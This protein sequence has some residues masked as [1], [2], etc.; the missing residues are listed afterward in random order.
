MGVF[1][2]WAGKYNDLGIN[3]IPIVENKKPP[4]DG[5]V[6]KKWLT[7]KQTEEDIENLIMA[8]GHCP[9][10]AVICG[11]VSGV[12]GFDFD[13]KYDASRMP[14]EITEKKYNMEFSKIDT[15][16]KKH[17]PDW[18][19]AKKAKHGWTV[20]YKWSP[21]H[22]TIPVDRHKVRLFDFKATGYIVIPPSFHSFPDGK[23]L[24]YSWICGDPMD[25]FNSLPE[26]DISIVEDFKEAFGTRSKSLGGRHG[27][28]FKYAADLVRI[29]VDDKIIA[30]KIMSYDISINASDKK[31]PYFKDKDHVGGD[32]KAFALK[33]VSRIRSFV[34]AKPTG[35]KTRSFGVGAWDHF[36][37]STIGEI[38][39]DI[40]SKKLFFR[41][42]Q[43]ADWDLVEGIEKVFKS[44]A[45]T[46]GFSKGDVPDELARYCF[47]KAEETFLCEIEAWEGVDWIQEI[48]KSI[49]SPAFNTREIRDIL[50]HW[51]TG[52][53][54]RINSGGESQNRCLIL[55]GQQGIGKDYLV[56]ELLKSF[57]PYYEV[58]SPPDQKKDWFEVVS[59]IY[60]AHIEEFDQ[61][62][63]TSVALLKSLITQESVFFRESYGKA[64]VNGRTAISFISTVNPDNFFR[65]STGNRR[66]VVLPVDEINHGYPKGKS[67]QILAQ[68]K[69][70][71]DK[72]GHFQLPAETEEKIKYIVEAL[73]PD[74]TDQEI[75]QI[76]AQRAAAVIDQ[77]MKFGSKN[78]EN[79]MLLDQ[80][81][82][83]P[84]ISDIARL[85]DVRSKTVRNILK[86]KGYQRRFSTGRFWA[87][88]AKS[89]YIR[90]EA[91]L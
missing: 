66:Y 65:D 61:T 90:S 11:E 47:E 76:W 48:S 9:G 21:R 20:F 24:F 6:F 57:K 18:T 77:R 10:I 1:G 14:S 75:E 81:A 37:E 74:R 63:N 87:P 42:T 43:N 16:F 85:T 35:E 83:G 28:I 86:T 82:A 33:W 12:S 51:G 71:F 7:Q 26:L 67:K 64:P 88:T 38:K 27:E 13:F 5:F 41:K 29:E 34:E 56:R 73:T 69:S 55:K 44:Y 32:P 23:E 72:I 8:Y 91:V 79:I 15:E 39:K 68:F 50:L 4:Q 70:V 19:L 30:E 36:I 49:K 78:L 89:H 25:E 60:V 53:F 59:R 40:L 80:D 52:I 54:S 22:Y 17:L 46:K 3:V 45:K 62:G 31:G 84:I 2:D 58:V